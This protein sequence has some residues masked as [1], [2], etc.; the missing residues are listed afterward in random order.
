LDFVVRKERILIMKSDVMEKTFETAVE[1]TENELEEVQ[2]AIAVAAQNLA[3]SGGFFSPSIAL[4][5]AAIATG[6]FGG[7]FC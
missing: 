3:L 2:G 4:N 6:G 5:Q 7:G 1:L